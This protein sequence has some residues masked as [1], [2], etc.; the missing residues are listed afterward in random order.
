MPAFFT[1]PC[2]A[3]GETHYVVRKQT[4]KHQDKHGHTIAQKFDAIKCPKTGRRF[5]RLYGTINE[6][7]NTIVS[8]NLIGGDFIEI[9]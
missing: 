4:I 6:T 5:R 1:K 2:L 8:S 7:K 3:C 9:I